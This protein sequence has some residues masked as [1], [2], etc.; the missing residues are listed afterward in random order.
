[1]RVISIRKIREFVELYPKSESAL[2][3]WH[4]IVKRARWE[5]MA[6]MKQ[7]FPSADLVGRRTVFNIMGGNF[8]LI[9]RVN[10]ARKTVFILTHQE[11]DRGRWKE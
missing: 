7:V 5:N 10:Y 8:R 11:Y 9:A 6:E 3:S 1:V 4:T 2:I